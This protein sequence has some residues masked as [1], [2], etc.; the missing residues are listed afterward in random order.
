MIEWI[1]KYWA[2]ITFVITFVI[3]LTTTDLQVKQ[4][5]E[6]IKCIEQKQNNSEI[7]L[8]DIRVELSAINTKLEMI[9][10]NSH[11]IITEGGK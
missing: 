2:Q 1:K 5:K 9:M 10:S 11:L 6:D 3:A 7:I 8:Q 4:N